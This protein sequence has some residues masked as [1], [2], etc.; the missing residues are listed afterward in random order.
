M[1]TS[2]R[3]SV[4]KPAHRAAK[5]K[6]KEEKKRSF[7]TGINGVLQYY[8][9]SA[10]LIACWT[11]SIAEKTKQNA[12]NWDDC[13][14]RDGSQPKWMERT[15]H[16]AL[17]LITSSWCITLKCVFIAQEQPPAEPWCANVFFSCIQLGLCKCTV[18]T[19]GHFWIKIEGFWG[20]FCC[21]LS[22]LWILYLSYFSL[23]P[24][25]WFLNF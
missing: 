10:K 15:P 24:L 16:L 7:P 20:N 2:F 4:A 8:S 12:S 11:Q 17:L 22:E 18:T 6:K 1:P 21:Q 13:A 23:N 14:L 19:V 3:R 25:R 5:Q 9:F